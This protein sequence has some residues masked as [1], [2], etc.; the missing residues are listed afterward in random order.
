MPN[1]TAFGNQTGNI[2]RVYLVCD[3]VLL[4]ELQMYPEAQQILVIDDDA[5]RRQLSVRILSDEG[6]AVT[7]VA[8]GFSAIRAASRRRFALAL[9]A[10]ALPGTLD[11]LATV[12]QLRARQPWLK[13]LFT[14]DVAQRAWWPRPGCDDFIAAPFHRRDL[15]GGVFELLQREVRRTPA[16]RGDHR[17]GRMVA[18]EATPEPMLVLGAAA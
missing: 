14:G 2:L 12:R 11:G 17:H 3:G 18:V 9:T 10:V 6:F 15:L 13:A 16:S 7:A 4:S 8:E 5:E 1:E